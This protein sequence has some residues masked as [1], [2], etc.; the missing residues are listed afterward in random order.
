MENEVMLC[1]RLSQINRRLAALSEWIG[2]NRNFALT[3]KLLQIKTALRIV[4][5]DKYLET[6]EGS[7]VIDDDAYGR[8]LAINNQLIKV[9]AGLNDKRDVET[10]YKLLPIADDLTRLVVDASMERVKRGRT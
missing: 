7:L 2:A 3:A 4:M 9:F 10:G 6:A 1:S 8:L 5:T